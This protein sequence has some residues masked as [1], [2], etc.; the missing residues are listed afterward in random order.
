MTESLKERL[1]S[2]DPLK[3]YVWRLRLT[4]Q[5]FH[6]LAA[7]VHAAPE[8]ITHEYAVMAIIYI[9]EWYKREYDGN[10]SNPI[11]F[12][13]AENLWRV[14][15]FDTETYVYKGKK[16]YRHLES[17][18]MLGGLPMKFITQ[19]RNKDLL[20]KLC[21]I[22]KGERSDLEDDESIGK[23]QAIAFQ[24]S[25]RQQASLYNFMK[26]LLLGDASQL[27][28]EEDLRDKSSL[29]NQFIETVNSAYDEVMHDKFR[30]EW[31]V[32]YK[33]ESSY[34]YRMV[35]LIL[36]P[37]ELGGLHQYLRFERAK[38][39]KIPNLMRQRQ[40]K[41][42]LRFKNGKDLVGNNETR[43]PIIRF[44]NSGQEDTGFE[45]SG[46]TNWAIQRCLPTENFDRLEIV[47]TD[48]AD[49]TYVIQT[50]K[51]EA[52]YLQLWAMQG[53]INR[54]SS[55]RNNQAETAVIFTNYYTLSGAESI[56]KPF[57]DIN[58]GISEPWNISFISDHVTLHH[59]GKPDITLWNRDGYI[60]FAP[61][62]YNNV[63][64]YNGG[65]VRYLYNEDP[66][67]Y[68]EPETEEWYQ[69][70]FCRNDIKAYHFKTR[71]A[72][73]I[74]PDEA[75]IQRIEFKPYTAAPN[76][77][78]VE[79]TEKNNPPY[80]RLKL[81]LTIKDDDKIYTVLYLPSMLEHGA[82]TPVVRDFIKGTLTYIDSEG[83]IAVINTNIAM[84][85]CPL[86]IACPLTVW[87][88][89]MEYVQLD[90]IQPTLIKEI[91]LDGRLTRYLKDGEEFIL[92]YLLKD[93]ITIHDFNRD[94]YFEFQCFNIGELKERGSIDLWRNGISPRTTLLTSEMPTY[95][96]VRFGAQTSE[97]SPE[98]LLYWEY[99]LDSWPKLVN[100]DF[101]NKMG[102]YSILFQDMRNVDDD[103]LC[104]PP[105]TR[106]Q[107]I[108]GATGFGN[109][110]AYIAS[111]PKVKEKDKQPLLCYDIATK[112]RT[113]YFI[114]NPLFRI[115]EDKFISDLFIPLRERNEGKFS[116]EDLQNLIRC[117]TELGFDWEKLLKKI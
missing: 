59:K 32:D 108:L 65:K 16:N 28:A 31:I 60:Q 46:C 110:G 78:Y 34:M 52:K 86:N 3:P 13:L 84:N 105:K 87:G 95:I 90:A 24:E 8:S 47:V 55:T 17:I 44:E 1:L 39:W 113:Y 54:W 41:V 25:I 94:G 83:S 4:E 91:Y 80:G 96:K 73:D 27:Y 42:S 12:V 101:A 57:Y 66:E 50:I 89:E 97:H 64:L 56:E 67:I 11:S 38:T 2:L 35:R 109:W 77:N 53:E 58:H 19:I 98:R 69:A 116:E 45:A 106:N 92:P 81:R 114:F 22:Y 112:Y 36:R 75:E 29:V 7:H 61:T 49:K 21:R 117:A 74:T 6:Q 102:N 51:C 115:T 15:G 79:W 111:P 72:V 26:T 14:S 88:N 43:R 5:E 71:N 82:N 10:V 48:D 62:L 85:K 18:Y 9:A 107:Q 30:I 68:S 63:L 37:E 33:P 76:D 100:A 99:K 23:N 104:I 40:L 93:R 20:K 103:L 70:I